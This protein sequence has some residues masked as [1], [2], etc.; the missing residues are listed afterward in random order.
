M[1][2]EFDLFDGN[3]KSATK[4]FEA[5]GNVAAA[6]LAFSTAFNQGREIPESVCREI[7]RF[8][9]KIAVK[10]QRA[11][12][13]EIGDKPVRLTQK[14]LASFWRGKDGRDPVGRFHKE[15]RDYHLYWALRKRIDQGMTL[16]A[17]AREVRK[18]PGVRLSERSLENL[19]ARLNTNGK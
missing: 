7:E 9:A 16:A 13:A 3:I 4:M 18:M 8:A 12:T 1:D 15:W 10:A 14:E 5:T 6:W 19:W 17:A 2:D 11:I